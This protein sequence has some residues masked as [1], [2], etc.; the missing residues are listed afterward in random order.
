MRAHGCLGSSQ[1][2]LR[3]RPA[4]AKDLRRP[5][6]QAE[7]LDEILA[8]QEDR[9]VTRNLILHYD[10]MMLVLNPTALAGGLLQEDGG[11]E[12][13]GLVGATPLASLPP[14]PDSTLTLDQA[15][16][17]ATAWISIS[18]SG[19]ASALTMIVAEPGRA[20]PKCFARAAPAAATSS[21]RT[22]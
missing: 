16:A 6:R 4:N 20:S 9:T 5:L 10:R 18:H 22:R 17:A 14:G 7:E 3:P 19:A 12:L 8:W 1:Y 15:F 2:E 13:L 11:N 21:G